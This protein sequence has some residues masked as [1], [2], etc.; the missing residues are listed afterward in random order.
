M[1]NKTTSN[2]R[3][4]KNTLMLYARMLFLM[5]I[6]LYASRVV[7]STLGV[8]DYGIYNAVGGFVAMFHIINGAMS[9]ATQRFLSFE[10][11][12]GDNCKIT[13]IFSTAIVIHVLLALLIL[14]VA[15]TLGVWFLNEKMVF[16]ND[17]YVAANL[18]FQL[19]I[20]TL[21]I[22]VVSV[23]YNAALIAYEKMSAFAYI[24]IV[25][26]ILKL[27]IVYLIM[28]IGGDKLVLYALLISMVAI[29]VRFTYGIYVNRHLPLC[30]NN[31]RMDKSVQKEIMSFVSWNLIGSTAG[32]VQQQGLSVLLNVF[33]GATVNAARGVSLQVMHAVAGFVSNF[34]LAM[35]PQIIKSYA[36]GQKEEMFDLAIRGSKFSFMLMLI[37][38]APIIIETPYILS[39][40]LVKVPE[41]SAIFVR[42]VLLIA[43]VDSMKH[44]MVASV[45]A[46]GKVKIY[47]LTNGIF[48]LMTIPL[49]YVILQ[50]GYPPSS[51]LITSLVISIVCH[52]IRLAVLWKIVKFPIEKYLKEVTLRMFF[53]SLLTFSLPIYI[54]V[55]LHDNFFH[56]MIVVISTVVFSVLMCFFIGLSTKEKIFFSNRV[57]KVLKR[58][59]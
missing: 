7:L 41:H 12:T 47:Q 13:K 44:T 36:N 29:G 25:D 58:I 22:N 23:P 20:F 50:I 31:W 32:I 43:L 46:S 17:R 37:L 38:S 1:S 4:A 30:R 40:W 34:N 48:S 10:I 53:L 52:F 24:S 11:G 19:S 54:Y 33:F 9:T 26:G 14:L 28:I 3:I 2:K 45:H 8:T 5:A 35:N 27:L 39:L 59:I 49:A 6:N 21:M 18:V 55:C 57:V 56:F 42:I 51:A 16:P 15:E